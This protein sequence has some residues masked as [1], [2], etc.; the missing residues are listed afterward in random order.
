MSIGGNDVGFGALA[1][2]ALTEDIGDLA[3]RR[4]ARRQLDALRSRSWRGPISTSS[5]SA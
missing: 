5:T 1:A 4:G 3:P 2:Y